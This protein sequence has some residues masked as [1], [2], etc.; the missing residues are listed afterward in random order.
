LSAPQAGRWLRLMLVAF[1]TNGIGPF[2]LKVLTEK[3]LDRYESQYLI[4]WYLGGLL[5]AL[6]AFGFRNL[7]FSRWEILLGTAMG[8]GSLGGQFFTGKALAAGIP[9]HIAFPITTG[10]SL[11]LV[12]LAGILVFKERVGPYGLAGL[13]I[14]ILSLIV[15]SLG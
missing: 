14:G 10:G 15:L 9:G 13:V 5:L 12:A 11:F 7:R 3:H 2:G 8:F 1:V 4:F 6:L